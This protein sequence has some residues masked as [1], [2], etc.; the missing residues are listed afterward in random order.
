M[1]VCL[2]AFF[3]AISKPIEIHKLFFFTPRKVLKQHYLIFFKR[4]ISLFLYFFK[5]FSVNLKSDYRKNKRGR[6]VISFA[7]KLT[8][9]R[10]KYT[11]KF[12][13]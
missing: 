2:F 12:L 9:H 3:S 13:H 6:N 5:D 1:S 8:E 7:N 11:G 10:E 4:G